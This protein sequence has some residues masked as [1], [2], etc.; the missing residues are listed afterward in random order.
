MYVGD[1]T[2]HDHATIDGK[3]TQHG[4]ESIAITNREFS[5]RKT[6]RAAVPKDKNEK[7]SDITSNQG[8]PINRYYPVDRTAF[9]LF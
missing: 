3:N 1:S 5:D 6:L 4:F 8:I 7:W 2:D 9:K